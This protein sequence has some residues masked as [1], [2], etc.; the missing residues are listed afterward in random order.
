M[1]VLNRLLLHGRRE[2]ESRTPQEFQ[3]TINP[4]MQDLV[5]ITHRHG[6]ERNY[7]AH[8][9]HPDETE[10]KRLFLFFPETEFEVFTEGSANFIKV[11]QNADAWRCWLLPERP[12][13]KAL[14]LE[15]A[16][17]V[18]AMTPGRYDVFRSGTSRYCQIM[19]TGDLP[20][21]FL[22]DEG[23]ITDLP[24]PQDV[25]L[26]EPVKTIK[27]RASDDPNFENHVQAV[28]TTI[29]EE[30]V[31]RLEDAAHRVAE[32]NDFVETELHTAIRRGAQTVLKRLAGG[33]VTRPGMEV[34]LPDDCKFIYYQARKQG[35]II[36]IYLCDG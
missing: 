35:R 10:E 19:R 36:G 13:K 27:E 7:V 5:G 14:R 24:S 21:R 17:G 8:V 34:T 15:I 12:D 25:T 29:M 4:A 2:G 33:K 16:L 20:T 1:M 18:L 6:G 28:I 11:N 32:I 31:M 3:L 23:N 30:R 22:H 26:S 9:P